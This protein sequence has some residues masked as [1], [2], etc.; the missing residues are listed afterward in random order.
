MLGNFPCGGNAVLRG[1][2][3]GSYEMEI[4]AAETESLVPPSAASKFSVGHGA[5]TIPIPISSG[6]SINGKAT[7]AD[8]AQ[9]N[10]FEGIRVALRPTV[11]GAIR[12]DHIPIDQAGRFEIRNVGKREFRLRVTGLPETHY[13]QAA[14][15]NGIPISAMVFAANSGAPAHSIELVFDDKPATVVGSVSTNLK[16]IPGAHL[17]PAPWPLPDGDE[18]FSAMK[19]ASADERA[20]FNF[21]GLVPGGYRLLA[22]PP[23]KVRSLSMPGEPDRLFNDAEKITLAKRQLRISNISNQNLAR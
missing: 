4:R 17:I 18:P 7:A 9:I 20:M 3:P 10:G 2:A 15:Y 13:L 22:V 1:F 16:L 23:E 6:P 21:A 19:T 12:H 8:G 14:R 5:T 11:Y